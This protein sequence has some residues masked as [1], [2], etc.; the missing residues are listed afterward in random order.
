MP[1]PSIT[2]AGALDLDPSI[3]GRLPC[4]YSSAFYKLPA[5]YD[6]TTIHYLTRVEHAFSSLGRSNVK[7]RITIKETKKE[8]ENAEGVEMEGDQHPL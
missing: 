6:S 4:L 7:I 5:P 8:K 2:W 1:A 3:S